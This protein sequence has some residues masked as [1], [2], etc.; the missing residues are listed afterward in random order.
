MKLFKSFLF[1]FFVISLIFSF[2]AVSAL[3]EV[4][5]RAEPSQIPLA[6]VNITNTKITSNDKNIYNISF[7]LTNGKGMQTG[8]K[9]GVSLYSLNEKGEPAVLVDEKVYGELLSMQADS[10]IEKS[11]VYN[12]PTILDGDYILALSS[13]NESGFPFGVVLVDKIKLVSSTKGVRILPETCVTKIEPK[14]DNTSSF[15]V[16]GPDDTLRLTCT[17]V[18]SDGIPVSVLPYFETNYRSSYGGVATTKGGDTKPITF[19]KLEKKT[20]SVVLPKGDKS[21]VYY[22]KMMLKNGEAYSNSISA[23]YTIEGANQA[24]ARL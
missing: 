18:N 4:K 10:S 19:N 16:L 9:Y 23:I 13:Q 7:T 6:E 1:S 12:A 20:F 14:T 22:V 8:V 3:D 21:Q 15:L 11:I 2:N 24:R 5:T 17:A